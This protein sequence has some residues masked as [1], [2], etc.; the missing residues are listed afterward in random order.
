[1]RYEY[2]NTGKMAFKAPF[3]TAII[4]ANVYGVPI[5]IEN[6]ENGEMYFPKG[7]RDEWKVPSSPYMMHF[8]DLKRSELILQ[9]MQLLTELSLKVH[10]RWDTEYPPPVVNPGSVMAWNSVL[11][12]TTSHPLQETV[13][14]FWKP[15]VKRYTSHIEVP[16]NQIYDFMSSTNMKYPFSKKG[17]KKCIY[18]GYKTHPSRTCPLKPVSASECDTSHP[19]HE[20][21]EKYVYEAEVKPLPPPPSDLNKSNDYLHEKLLPFLDQEEKFHEKKLDEKLAEIQYSWEE[22]K[23][24]YSTYYL[25]TTKGSLYLLAMGFPKH[26]VLI[27]AIGARANRDFQYP[28]A[29]IV[30][31]LPSEEDRATIEKEVHK[32]VAAGR[33][34]FCPKSALKFISRPQV[35]KEKDKDRVVVNPVML[36]SAGGQA[37][38]EYPTA[39][40]LLKVNKTVLAVIQDMDNYFFQWGTA[41]EYLSHNGIEIFD[42]GGILNILQSWASCRGRQR[43]P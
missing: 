18:C 9:K 4:L 36:N 12:N 13:P 28:P 29:T 8:H 7:I 41:A 6:H 33:M 22:W 37:K 1:M 20:I 38:T 14:A 34:I 2:M 42:E 39:D 10:K 15:Y 5:E 17:E 31:P 11:H 40:T 30:T 21:I 16:I 26:L 23:N 27:A 32:H 24:S 35:V 25:Q 3:K 43:P 19:A